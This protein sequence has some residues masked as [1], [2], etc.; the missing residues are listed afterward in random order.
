MGN[1]KPIGVQSL[2]APERSKSDATVAQSWRA[3]APD[4]KARRAAPLDP[5]GLERL[6]L[7]YVERFATSRAKLA[8]YLARKLEERGWAGDKPAEIDALVARL[9]GLGYV[10]DA[11]FATARAAGLA[12]RGYGPRR[13]GQALRAA[14]IDEEDAGAARAHA[15]ETAWTAALGFARRRRIG[16]YAATPPDRAAREKAYA[17]LLRAGHS[18]AHAR[19]IIAAN[20]GHVPEEDEG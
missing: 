6:A 16:P 4:G 12:R 9:A 17:A 11:A 3:K 15:A 10:D 7:R 18:S 19:R 1:M 14:G 20:P 8:A 5:A 2:T 13:V